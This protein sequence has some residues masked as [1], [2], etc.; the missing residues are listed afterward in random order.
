MAQVLKYTVINAQRVR[1][2]EPIQLADGTPATAS[3][4]RT[5]IEAEPFAAGGKTLS[6]VLDAGALDD[7]PENAVLT[8]TIEVASAEQEG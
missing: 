5:I 8:V 2:E 4:E 6:V 7:F 1:V 3:F